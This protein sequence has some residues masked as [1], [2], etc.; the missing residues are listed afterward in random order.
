MVQTPPTEIPLF[1]FPGTKVSRGVG[2]PALHAM[3]WE[4]RVSVEMLQFEQQ[5]KLARG[6]RW[7]RSEIVGIQYLRRWIGT[8][9]GY[10]M[11]FFCAPGRY[12]ALF[13]YHSRWCVMKD[14]S[15]SGPLGSRKGARARVH[16]PSACLHE[17]CRALRVHSWRWFRELI[18]LV[19][20]GVRL[21]PTNE[22][23]PSQH[24]TER[25]HPSHTVTV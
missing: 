6:I 3:T 23:V 4:P 10:I 19:C 13:S 5:R 16:L 15:A 22:K 14:R 7:R 17:P 20:G 25:K 8:R 21:K 12:S 24:F 18:C 2:Y 1:L 11:F 9:F